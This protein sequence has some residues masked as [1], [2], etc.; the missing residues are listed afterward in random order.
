MNN[1]ISII[2]LLLVGGIVLCQTWLAVYTYRKIKL[3]RNIVPARDFFRIARFYLPVRHL[4]EQEPEV[5]LQNIH[6]Y[7]TWHQQPAEVGDD[8]EYWIN[9]VDGNPYERT[10]LA[11]V[12]LINP[13]DE[14][15]AIFDDILLSINVYLLKNKGAVADFNLVKDIVERN[16]DTEEDG[17][18]QMITVPLYLG[19]MGTMVGIVF[20]LANL[21]LVVDVNTDFDI[22][23]FLGGVSIAMFSSF[24]GL[25]CTVVNSSFIFKSA[26]V[27]SEKAKNSFYTFIQT[28]LL[29]VLN[30][31]VSSSIHT[32]EKSLIGF[33]NGFANNL[34]SLSKLLTQ[35]HDALIAQEKIISSLENI[36]INEFAKANIT[37]LQELKSGVEQLSQFNQYL[38]SL[39]YLVSG[40]SRLAN[41]FEELLTRSNNFQDLAVKLDRRI[42]DSN[43]LVQF[44]NDHFQQLGERGTIIRE[45]VVKV[46]DV[47]IKSLNQLEVHT[48]NKIES[49]K[50]ITIKE[51]DLMTQAFAENRSHIS[52][53]SLLEELNR[54]MTDF[55]SGSLSCM[56]ELKHASS[57]NREAIKDISMLLEQLNE[58]IG[59]IGLVGRMH[60]FWLWITEKKR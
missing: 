38:N 20:G 59:K 41:S 19:L 39:N 49:I 12:S 33:N 52:K 2:E 58:N 45:S 17:I 13:S 22:K 40:T 9:A 3:L 34:G 47:M 35:N 11:E 16:I 18:N 14:S 44:L 60:Q 26:R 21:F 29:P 50:S 32:L 51:E 10:E 15:N 53:L 7:Q 25:F 55:K 48:Q 1:N 54:N 46:E 8:T 56:E 5:L 4:N 6:I 28:R 30:Q 37:I 27:R 23:G 36:N 43:K 31:S 57:K 24:W 42:E